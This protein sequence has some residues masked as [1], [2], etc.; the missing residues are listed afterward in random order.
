MNNDN[1]RIPTAD[2]IK[3]VKGRGFLLDKTTGR[4]F[5][6]RVIT[7]NGRVKAEVLEILA[8]AA[9]R[10]GN[11]QVAF[12]TRLTVEVQSIAYENIPAF[13]AFLAENGLEVGGTGPKVRPIVS[14][15]GTTCHF[16]LVD[17]YAL[18]EKIHYAFYKGYRQ[19][20]L[21]H[22]CKIAVGGCPN[23]CVKP[24]LN[25]IG[26]VGRRVPKMNTALCRGCKSCAMEK[27]CPIGCAKVADGKITRTADCNGCGRCIGKCPFGVCDEGEVGYQLF[28]GGRWGKRTAKGMPLTVLLHTEEEVMNAVESAILFFK[29]EGVAGERLADTVA[30]VGFDKAEK[31]IL[32]GSLLARKQEILSR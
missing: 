17:T 8:E 10:F 14:C 2:E 11:G 3:A 26:I 27:A 32:D 30:R 15:K 13:E 6:A 29:S 20:V 16:G 24:D 25:D 22:K 7:V 4:H 18:S 31:M 9:R 5:N 19:V 28:I 12:T 23:N 21:P 1:V